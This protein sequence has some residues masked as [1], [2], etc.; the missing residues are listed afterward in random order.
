MHDTAYEI[1]RL[2]FER[3]IGAGPATVVD[4]GSRDVN[5]TLRDFSGPNIQYIGLDIES[6]PSVDVQI[7]DSTNLPI[8]S[9]SVDAIIASSMFEHDAI[10]WMTFL[11]MVR[12]LK[13]KGFLYVSA[14]SNGEVHRYPRD[15]WRFYPDAG[16]A[17]ETWAHRN[18]HRL[19]LVESFTANRHRDQWNDFC[20]IYVKPQRAANEAK[21]I[22]DTPTPIAIDVDATNVTL[23]G[24]P[25]ILNPSA[26][27]EDMRIMRKLAT[28]R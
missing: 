19:T 14:P 24:V 13:P 22:I 8:A 28:N 7:A 6:G 12:I 9:A 10:F 20:A 23:L 2:F 25:E 11:E 5:G 21:D 26:E 15:C 18:G 17:L 27:T 3:Y 16:R 4:L 1:G